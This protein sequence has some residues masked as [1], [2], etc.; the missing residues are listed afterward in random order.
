LVRDFVEV[1]VEIQRGQN[2]WVP[3]KNSEGFVG[4]FSPYRP[5]SLLSS[6]LF[7][8]VTKFVPFIISTSWVNY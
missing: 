6:R 7:I 8:Q 1:L 3:V 2:E 4:Q 5:Y